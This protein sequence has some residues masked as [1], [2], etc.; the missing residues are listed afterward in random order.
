MCN[1]LLVHPLSIQGF[2]HQRWNFS[3]NLKVG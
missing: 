2:D 3:G 1:S